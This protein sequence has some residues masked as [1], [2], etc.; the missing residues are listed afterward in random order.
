MPE[1]SINRAMQAIKDMEVYIG[2]KRLQLKELLARSLW[3]DI[4]ELLDRID[5]EAYQRG[6]DEEQC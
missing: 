2:I 6:K 1:H 4:E 5:A 3:D